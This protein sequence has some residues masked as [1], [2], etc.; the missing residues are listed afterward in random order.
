MFDS[1][2]KINLLLIPLLIII[3]L[4]HARDSYAHPGGT[5]ADGCHYC[6]TNCSKWGEIDGARHCHGA[7]SNQSAPKPKP[8]VVLTPIPTSGA[9]S[10]ISPTNISTPTPTPSPLICPENSTYSFV[11]DTC[12]CDESYEQDGNTCKYVTPEN[13]QATP[14]VEAVDD[15]IGG[16]KVLGSEDRILNE[17]SSGEETSLVSLLLGG[18][19]VVGGAYFGYKLGRRKTTE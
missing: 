3:S 19:T 6:R 12:Q 16:E 18:L 2:V 15:A 11:T 14:V 10:T 5:A 13:S 7:T 1:S 8:T 17:E 4:F 9:K